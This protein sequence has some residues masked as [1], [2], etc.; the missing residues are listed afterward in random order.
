MT[1]PLVSCVIPVFNGE[2]YLA[3]TVESVIRQTYAPVEILVVDD[4]SSDRT[5][6]VIRGFGAAV[7][8]VEQ[9]H[10]GVAAAR[11]RGIAA[12]SAEFIAFLDADDVWLP[13]K[14]ACQMERFRA[15]ADVEV[16][17]TWFEDFWTDGRAAPGAGWRPN[18]PRPGYSAPAMVAR[19][20]VFERVGL[21]DE[22]LRTA[23]CR[24]WFIRAREHHVVFDVLPQ[25]LVRHRLHAANLSRLPQKFDDYATLVKRHLDRQRGR[26]M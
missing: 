24:D 9:S 2:R 12:A 1:T 13:D 3:E 14:L 5:R 17:L 11:N 23:S 19:R 20:S 15:R 21:F 8:A 26:A 18:T 4:G 6:D 25:V 22:G 10:A 7:R 16:S